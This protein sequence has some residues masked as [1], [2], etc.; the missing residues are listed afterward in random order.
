MNRLKFLMHGKQILLLILFYSVTFIDLTSQE[1]QRP[2]V[3]NHPKVTIP[4]TEFRSLQSK[5]L[6][7]EMEIYLKIPVSYYSSPQ[8]VYPVLYMTD[9]NRSFPMLANILNLFEVP[10]P[11]DPEILVVG[12]GYKIRDMTDWGAWRMRDLTP[13]NDPSVDTIMNKLLTGISGRQY[14]VKSGDAAKFLEFIANEVIPFVQSNYRASPVTR[15]IGGYSYG[16]LFSLYVLFKQTELF[17]IYYAGSPSINYDNG[18]LF[19]YE[20]EYASSH[21]DMSAK[22]FMSA[23]GSEDS[24]TIANIEMMGN[25]LKSHSYSGLKIVT[26]VFPGETHVSCI[27]SS[28]TRALNVLYNKR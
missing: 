5:V 24:L 26:Q 23:G 19:K 10:R 18:I 13:T 2:Q 6:G 22:I 16:G 9:G 4:N 25:F 17:N 28:I 21:K 14:K 1:K 7:Q 8:K 27:P 20:K 15:G 11:T 12:I 3:E